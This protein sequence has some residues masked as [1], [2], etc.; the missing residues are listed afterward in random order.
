MVRAM[1]FSEEMEFGPINDPQDSEFNVMMPRKWAEGKKG[2]LFIKDFSSHA[3]KI[4]PVSYDRISLLR[5]KTMSKKDENTIEEIVKSVTRII[6]NYK[7]K[8]IYSN[9][10]CQET[11]ECFAEFVIKRDD[12]LI[13]EIGRMRKERDWLNIDDIMVIHLDEHHRQLLHLIDEIDS[14]EREKKTAGLAK[15]IETKPLLEEYFRMNMTRAKLIETLKRKNTIDVN[16]LV[17]ELMLELSYV[18]V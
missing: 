2:A 3:V 11:F 16:P 14:V 18:T 1:L 13:S 8:T 4:I 17:H 5:I 6:E 15:T 9:G 7:I 10:I 12:E